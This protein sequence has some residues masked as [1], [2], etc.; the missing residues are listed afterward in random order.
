[1]AHVIDSAIAD[2][3][4][5]EHEIGILTFSPADSASQRFPF[6]VL[7]NDSVFLGLME[8]DALCLMADG[9]ICIYD[10]EV[11]DRVLCHAASSQ[12]AFISALSVLKEYFEKCVSDESYWDDESAAV[13]VRKQC[14]EIAGGNAHNGFFCGLI[15]S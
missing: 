13:S 1:M 11:A 15:G 12:T 5:S 2:W 4:A 3:Q 14:A 9:S 6:Y 8:A 10:H 7:P